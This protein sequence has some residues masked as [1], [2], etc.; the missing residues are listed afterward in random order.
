MT[1]SV[2]VVVRRPAPTFW[3]WRCFCSVPTE[4]APIKSPLFV[5]AKETFAPLNVACLAVTSNSFLLASDIAPNATPYS[6]PVL[7][8]I[9]I[10]TAAVAVTFALVPKAV[11]EAPLTNAFAPNA[12]P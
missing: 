8:S 5:P 9:P 7:A 4:T 10:A 12:E 6:T 11:P 3:I 1:A 2:E